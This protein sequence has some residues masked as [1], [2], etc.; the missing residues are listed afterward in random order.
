MKR[1]CNYFFLHLNI[2]VV[3]LSK[4]RRHLRCGRETASEEMKDGEGP[5]TLKL[6]TFHQSDSLWEQLAQMS[7]S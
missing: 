6:V 3:S 2:K 1:K 4:Q 5:F 7:L